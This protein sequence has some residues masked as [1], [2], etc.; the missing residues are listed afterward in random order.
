M[1]RILVLSFPDGIWHL[2]ID[3]GVHNVQGQ[4]VWA[5]RPIPGGGELVLGQSS[6][7]PET[8]FQFESHSAFLGEMGQ[9]N[10][11]H[12]TLTLSEVSKRIFSF[13]LTALWLTQGPLDPLDPPT[14]TP[15][16]IE[17]GSDSIATFPYLEYPWTVHTQIMPNQC[18]ITQAQEASGQLHTTTL[19]SLLR[20]PKL[21][22]LFLLRTR[23]CGPGSLEYPMCGWTLTL[24]DPQNCLQSEKSKNSRLCMC[25]S[26]GDKS[27]RQNVELGSPRINCQILGPGLPH[28]KS[29]INT[30]TCRS[31]LTR[32]TQPANH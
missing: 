6:R 19:A 9:V 22:F 15:P 28:T 21:D 18:P 17:A 2:Y 5:Q 11:W 14:L 12:R 24:P 26:W 20:S 31:R 16:L 30:S 7:G 1:I 29:S 4:A 27:F 8:K 10:I 13:V 32:K 3:G 25:I 23:H